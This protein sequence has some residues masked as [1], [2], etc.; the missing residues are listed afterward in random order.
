MPWLEATEKIIDIMT[1]C[2][3]TNRMKYVN[4]NPDDVVGVVEQNKKVESDD[5]V[6]LEAFKLE[7]GGGQVKVAS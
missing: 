6:N 2:I 1:H 3:S 4:K 5:S 7:S